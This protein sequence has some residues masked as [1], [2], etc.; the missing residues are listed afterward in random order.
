MSTLLAMLRTS[1]THGIMH[2]TKSST[3]VSSPPGDHRKFMEV[4]IKQENFTIDCQSR[5]AQNIRELEASTIKKMHHQTCPQPTS[6]LVYSY[7]SPYQQ[8][9]HRDEMSDGFHTPSPM[10]S[11]VSP[12]HSTH[13]TDSEYYSIGKK[14]NGP[15]TVL[16]SNQ[17]SP[18]THEELSANSAT[19][20][21]TLLSRHSANLPSPLPSEQVAYHV[22]SSQSASL[23]SHYP[24]HTLH[25]LVDPETGE[26][27]VTS[28]ATMQTLL[29]LQPGP[30]H[31]LDYTTGNV[32]TAVIMDTTGVSMSENDIDMSA[33]PVAG[34]GVVMDEKR[35]A[36]LGQDVSAE[37]L[38]STPSVTTTGMNEAPSSILTAASPY[39][40]EQS[41]TVL[42]PP[43]SPKKA[44][45]KKE[46]KEKKARGGR[47]SNKEDK[48]KKPKKEKEPKEKKKRNSRQ[49]N[50]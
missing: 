38:H 5:L 4:K 47:K 12:A 8:H 2:T 15:Y 1:P 24:I 30:G 26:R 14:I 29:P 34:E 28:A 10:S 17:I 33:L 40:D 50:F 49:V 11:P 25:T 7:T 44:N 22:L 20:H 31:I 23:E 6:G 43:P 32:S 36:M 19:A 16:A 27:F 39:N 46:P 42:S 13:T 35:F 18:S 48:A 41:V 9:H 21:I 3:S 37:H 45:S